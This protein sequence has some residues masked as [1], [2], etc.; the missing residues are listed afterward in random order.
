[1]GTARG[2][3]CLT[4]TLTLVA[5]GAAAAAV[6]WQG[7]RSIRVTVSNPSLRPPFGNARTTAFVSGGALTRA[8]AALNAHHIRRV[9]GGNGDDGGCTGGY[10]AVITIVER[11]RTRVTLRAY[12]CATTTYG[13]I[14]GDL[15]GFLQ[16]LGITPP[17]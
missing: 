13:T 12:R 5:C 16:A 3:A 15:P 8:Q 4:L 6:R 10:D 9:N 17:G 11:D 14:G 1:M 2:I 7:V